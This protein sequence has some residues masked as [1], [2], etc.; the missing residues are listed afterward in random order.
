MVVLRLDCSTAAL[1]T[2]QKVLPNWKLV[3]LKMLDFCDCR[4]TGTFI[5]TS[6]VDKWDLLEQC[7]LHTCLVCISNNVLGPECFDTWPN[8]GIHNGNIIRLAQ[9]PVLLF[10]VGQHCLSNT[11][12]ERPFNC[13]N[14]SKFLHKARRWRFVTHDWICLLRCQRKTYTAAH[15]FTAEQRHISVYGDKQFFLKVLFLYPN[16]P[17]SSKRLVF[18]MVHT[19]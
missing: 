1:P 3:Y 13:N 17:L 12:T 14:L 11:I 16:W 7:F 19:F 9:A 10:F 6:A 15:L 8:L 2:T 5:F 4:K 18:R